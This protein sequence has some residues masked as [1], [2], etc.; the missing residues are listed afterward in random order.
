MKIFILLFISVSVFAH[1]GDCHNCNHTK[2]QESFA[3]KLLNWFSTENSVVAKAPCK[4][5]NVPTDQEM[6]AFINSKLQGSFTWEVN[7]VQLIDESPI[8]VQAFTDFTTAKDWYGISAMKINQKNFQHEFGINPECKKALC[9][10]EKIWGKEMAVKMLYV[11]LKHGYNVSEFAF[12]QSVRFRKDELDDVIKALEDLP[13]HLVP[14]ALKNQRLTRF[15]SSGTDDNKTLANAV[16]MLYDRWSEKYS[17]AR[18]YTIFHE[19][20]HNIATKIKNIDDNPEWLALSGW[21]KLGDDWEAA[22]GQCF[23]SNYAKANAWEDFAETLSA[24][25]YNGNVLKKTCPA[26]YQFMKDKVMNGLEY[27]SENSC[28]P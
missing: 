14:V 8:L 6:R 7:G 18:Q 1:E 19:L 10:L 12:D 15:P 13:P 20:A 24:Y 17:T 9:A 4:T 23:I 22:P 26:K 16:I 5:K 3:Q 27:I 21:M 25:R 11:K 2:I 28:K